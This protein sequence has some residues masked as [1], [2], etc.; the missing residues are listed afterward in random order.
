MRAL[1]TLSNRFVGEVVPHVSVGAYLYKNA[2]SV[3]YNSTTTSIS[4]RQS[5]TQKEK[6][7]VFRKT[8]NANVHTQIRVY[9]LQ[10]TYNG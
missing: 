3:S 5:D 7:M 1:S 6:K 2:E 9:W 4:W 10:H 8:P